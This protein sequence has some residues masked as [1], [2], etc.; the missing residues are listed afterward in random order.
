MKLAQP[1]DLNYA[2][3]WEVGVC[4]VSCPPPIVGTGLPLT[5]VGYTHVFVY[6]NV[7]SPQFVGIDM[8]RF[9]RT[10]IF[11]STNCNNIFYKIYYVTDEQ[12][13]FQ[14]IRIEFLNTDGKRVPFKESKIPQKLFFISIRITIVICYKT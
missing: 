5:A 2:E 7:I 9:L 3:N 8:V 12:R 1:I 4:E 14:G 13:K 6:C 11:P 10:F